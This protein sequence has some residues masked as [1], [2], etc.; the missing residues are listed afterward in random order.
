MLSLEDLRKTDEMDAQDAQQPE[1]TKFVVNW[2][3]V[4]NRHQEE[5]AKL[6][7]M[8]PMHAGVEAQSLRAE[9]TTA[10]EIIVAQERQLGELR[11]VNQELQDSLVDAK[12]AAGGVPAARS[13]GEIFEELFRADTKVEVLWGG[14]QWVTPPR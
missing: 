8:L 2:E 13:A 9:L 11:R 6:R 10:R 14:P 3:Q 4:V 1:T 5:I 12:Q 7:R